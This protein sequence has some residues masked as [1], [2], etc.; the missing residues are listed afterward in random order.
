MNQR[1]QLKTPNFYTIRQGQTKMPCFLIA[2]SQRRVWGFRNS[3][4]RGKM[5]WVWRHLASSTYE[6]YV[7]EVPQTKMLPIRAWCMF[8]LQFQ[9]VLKSRFYFWFLAKSKCILLYAASYEKHSVGHNETE[10]LCVSSLCSYPQRRIDSAS[11]HESARDFLCDWL[12]SAR[13]S[14]ALLV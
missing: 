8:F 14:S 1:W 12:Q 13:G 10:R 2:C 5:A 9:Q 11:T 3:L 7:A 4:T 6:I